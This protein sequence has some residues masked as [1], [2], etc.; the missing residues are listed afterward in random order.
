M[1]SDTETSG[2]A[3]LKSFTNASASLSRRF[4]TSSLVSKV[5]SQVQ[6]AVSL[7]SK[8][9]DLSAVKLIQ[10]PSA[11]SIV[12]SIV[13]THFSASLSIMSPE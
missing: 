10:T 11:T 3:S 1:S 7:Q 9:G 5:A 12:V 2:W 8:Y 13:E 4:S 6:P